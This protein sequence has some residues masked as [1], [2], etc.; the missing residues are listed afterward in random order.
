VLDDGT[1]L[2]DN[3]VIVNPSHTFSFTTIDFTANGGDNYPFAA[4][5]VVFENSPFTITYQEALANYVKAPKAEGGLQRLSAADGDEITANLYGIENANDAYG[6]LIDQAIATVTPGLTR[7]G[8]AG[9][10][11]INGTS[12]DDILIGGVGAD[13][14]T[15]GSG[16]DKF[17]FNSMRDAGDTVTDFTPYADKLKLTT[18][19]SS[20]GIAPSQAISNQHVRFVDITGGV[21]VQ[22]DADGAGPAPSRALA[23]LKGLTAK[24]L[25]AG[26]DLEM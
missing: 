18:L 11:V 13:T 25:V 9:R 10:D 20:L 5:G 23:T 3:G 8:T 7:S 12:G 14:V 19:L 24:Q 6:R 22:I 15:G 21:S 2:I 4:N 26:R 17:V 1:V 16:G